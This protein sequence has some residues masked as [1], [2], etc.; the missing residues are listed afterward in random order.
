MLTKITFRIDKVRP[1]EAN[2]IIDTREPR[3]LFYVV[4]KLDGQ[5][6]YTGIDN[7]DGNAWTE[8]FKSLS[9]CKRWL[10]GKCIQRNNLVW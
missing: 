3:G 6:V 5:T 1:D 2:R 9:T 7:W 10:E 8:D 4:G